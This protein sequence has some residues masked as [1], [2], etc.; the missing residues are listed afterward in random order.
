MNDLIEELRRVHRSVDERRGEEL[1]HVVELRRSYDAGVQDVWDACTDPERIPGWFLPV[2]GEL[3]RG[4]RFQLEGNAGGEIVECE[5]S[6]RLAVTWEFGGQSSLVTLELS[7]AGGGATELVLRHALPDDDHWARFG[8]GAVAIGWE[9][10]LH[11][12]TAYLQGDPVPGPDQASADPAAREFM[13]RSA[14]AWGEA[15]VAGGAP[16]AAAEESAAR[17]AAAYAPEPDE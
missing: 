8:P 13:R 17:T 12:L 3:Q 15:H 16:A 11:G 9:L 14:A 2:S 5:P 7:A 1:E 10:S 4:G 6:R